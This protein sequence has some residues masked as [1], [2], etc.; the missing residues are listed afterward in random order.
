[1]CYN[2]TKVTNIALAKDICMGGVDSVTAKFYLCKERERFY[3]VEKQCPRGGD[4][5]IAKK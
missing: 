4:R 1:M 2:V 3:E 5:F